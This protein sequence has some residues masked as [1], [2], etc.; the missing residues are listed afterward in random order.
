M[1]S[2]IVR[3]LHTPF[4]VSSANVTIIRISFVT[5][6]FSH[7]NLRDSFAFH[8]RSDEVQIAVFVSAKARKNQGRKFRACGR[9]DVKYG[10]DFNAQKM[11]PLSETAHC[12]CVPSSGRRVEI[13]TQEHSLSRTSAWLGRRKFVVVWED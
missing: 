2:S 4:S 9:K 11:C 8:A 5:L 1:I 7:L 6:D 3:P 13:R 12:S 10:R